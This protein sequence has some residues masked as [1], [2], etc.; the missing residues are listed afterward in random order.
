MKLSLILFT[1]LIFSK[2][3]AQ[4][5]INGRDI[6]YDFIIVGAGGAGCA[7]ANR[8]SEEKPWKILLIEAGGPETPKTEVP[9][10]VTEILSPYES[11]LL[12]N[13]YSEPLRNAGSALNGRSIRCM[14]GK[15]MGG[16]SAVNWMLYTRGNI[17]DYNRWST[18]TGDLNWSWEY[19]HPYYKKLENYTIPYPDPTYFGINGPVHIET[20]PYYSEISRLA[21]VAG[22]QSGLPIRN[23]NGPVSYGISPVQAMIKNGVR[24]SASKA[25]ITPIIENRPNLHLKMRSTVTKI[26][27]N[28]EARPLP[29]AYGVRY[30]YNDVMYTA[31]AR[32]EV[33]LCAGPINS[34]KLLMLSGIG[35]QEDLLINQG[36]G[37]SHPINNTL[38]IE[39]ILY[40]AP[41]NEMSYKVHNI[42]ESVYDAVFKAHSKLP[43]FQIYPILEQPK[44]RG[45]VR[46]RDAN[47]FSKPR[48]DLN[49][50]SDPEDLERLLSGVKEAIKIGEKPALESYSP[51][52][53][54]TKIPQCSMYIFNTDAYWRCVIRAMPISLWHFSGTCKM[55]GRSDPSTVLNTRLKVHGIEGLR[56]VDPSAFPTPVT[57]H[58]NALSMM[59]GEKAADIIKDDLTH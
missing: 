39:Q 59:I 54:S 41:M 36:F 34:P 1:I 50:F 51:K 35:P 33:I 4:A 13:D 27:I 7:L 5:T 58:Y 26:L 52:L 38:S 20:P 28:M 25:Y 23:V 19:I 21:L 43:G 17:A 44:S 2:L 32:Q 31:Y 56:V 9:G 16:S 29:K 47:P 3:S 14:H 57:A 6:E 24:V 12:W 30:L 11:P 46:L 15:V 48:I 53:L 45:T 8:L 18:L 49:Y 40:F 37:Y 10:A 22:E 55:G 42:E